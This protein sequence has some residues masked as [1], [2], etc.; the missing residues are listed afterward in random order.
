M[1]EGKIENKHCCGLKIGTKERNE[2]FDNVATI[3]C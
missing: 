2:R 3:N 1:F